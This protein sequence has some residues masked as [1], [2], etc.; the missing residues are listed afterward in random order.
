VQS[1]APDV[2]QKV[3]AALENWQFTPATQ[4]G[5]AIASQQYVYFHFP[6]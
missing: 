6:S 2:D 5:R 4:D 1:V 3:L